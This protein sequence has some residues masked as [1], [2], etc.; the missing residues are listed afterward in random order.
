[1]EVRIY[2]NSSRPDVGMKP[3]RESS[4]PLLPQHARHCPVLEAGSAA[5][6][7]IYPPL[8]PNESFHIEYEGDGRYL[9]SYFLSGSG[10]KWE[11]IFSV[12]IVLPAGSIGVI[13][14]EV[15]FRIRKPP[16]DQEGAKRMMRAF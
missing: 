12:T 1:M 11:P 13:K 10:A 16:I 2:P 3:R 15:V 8:E 4:R 14:E 9:F 7:L 5:G 6:F